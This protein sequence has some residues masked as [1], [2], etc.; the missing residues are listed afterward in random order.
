MN[1]IMHVHKT[2]NDRPLTGDDNVVAEE[3]L[4]VSDSGEEADV[5]SDGNDRAY[6]SAL[7][8]VGAP[9]LTS[10]LKPVYMD[11]EGMGGLTSSHVLINQKLR[12]NTRLSCQ[13]SSCPPLDFI[14]P[15]IK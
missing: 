7:T 11:L 2:D 14:L 8:D 3:I 10:T 4:E 13:R 1:L 12:C 9:I 5:E 6:I 15:H